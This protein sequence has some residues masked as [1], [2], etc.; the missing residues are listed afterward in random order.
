MLHKLNKDLQ[1]ETEYLSSNTIEN[2]Y[3]SY[4]EWANRTVPQYLNNASKYLKWKQRIKNISIGS[5]ITDV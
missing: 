3:E 1:S 2:W 5:L 4:I